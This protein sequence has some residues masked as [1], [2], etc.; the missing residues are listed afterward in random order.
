MGE[1]S[2]S[3]ILGDAEREREI[4]RESVERRQRMAL[5]SRIRE[6]ES[7]LAT[8]GERMRELLADLKRCWSFDES[9]IHTHSWHTKQDFLERWR[10]N[11]PDPQGAM[12]GDSE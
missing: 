5:Q 8:A 11:T 1:H 7:A 12:D 6:L 9:Q 4:E 3:E 10:I 2:F